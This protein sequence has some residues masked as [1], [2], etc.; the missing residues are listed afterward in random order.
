MHVTDVLGATSASG[1]VL[2]YEPLTAD[3]VTSVLSTS[4]IKIRFDRLLHPTS[5]TRQAICLQPLLKKVTGSGDCTAGLFLE[6]AYDPV[7]REVTYRLPAPTR[8]TPGLVYTLTVYAAE[9]PQSAGFRSFLGTPLDAVSRYELRILPES[10]PPPPDD[11]LPTGDRWCASA[12]PDCGAICAGSCD[13]E[14]GPDAG[15]R[16]ACVTGCERACP[17]SIAAIFGARGCASSGCHGDHEPAAGLDLGSASGVRRTAI[18]VVA[19]GAQ[20]GGQAQAPE[21]SPAR[22]GRAMPILAPGAPGHSYLV[23]KLLASAHTPLEVPLSPREID[24]VRAMIVVGAPMP[25]SNAP[26]ASLRPGEAEWIAD[27]ILQRAP[28]TDACP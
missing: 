19:H 7:R 1:G 15:C 20:T 16:A 14:C 10:D 21:A 9:D 23:Y 22:F 13:A 26:E 5:A 3:G 4:A 28:L 18:D 8:L 11:T 24:R 6:P 2:R 25:P 12:E 17:R 27:W